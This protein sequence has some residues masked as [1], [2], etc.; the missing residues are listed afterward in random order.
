MKKNFVDFWQSLMSRDSI[1]TRKF[2][3][4]TREILKILV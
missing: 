2:K 1:T 3:N 4:P